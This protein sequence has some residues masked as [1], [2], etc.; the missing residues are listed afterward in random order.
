MNTT[1]FF[2]ELIVI[3]LGGSLA[4]LI[5]L[6]PF[7]DQTNIQAILTTIRDSGNGMLALAV[8]PLVYLFGILIDRIADHFLKRWEVKIKFTY[9]D[10]TDAIRDARTLVFSKTDRL[11]NLLE[12]NRS[13]L[14]ICRGWALNGLLLL[15]ATNVAIFKAE[16]LSWLPA[17]LYTIVL[18]LFTLLNF[19]IWRS[20]TNKE[21][22]KLKS[23]AESLTRAQ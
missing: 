9:F 23:Y 5:I 8:I 6:Y 1:N 14:R 20:L 3:G 21:F 2:V 22:E 15:I 10:S 12:Y 13:R 11:S 16:T 19:L 4:L 17:V 7:V 18:S